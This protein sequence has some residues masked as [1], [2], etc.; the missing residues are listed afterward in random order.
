M[1]NGN[2]MRLPC[3]A[4][5]RPALPYN[6]AALLTSALAIYLPHRV[7]S[8][9]SEKIYLHFVCYF[10]YIFLLFSIFTKL[11]FIEFASNCHDL[12]QRQTNITYFGNFH[13]E[14][15]LLHCCPH[16]R[17]NTVFDILL[18]GVLLWS[19]VIRIKNCSFGNY[20]IAVMAMTF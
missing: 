6:T 12:L 14:I 5:P 8:E 7:Y 16:L 4:L 19:S 20:I 3:P 1:E 18:G 10:L 17:F 2:V 9:N 13:S 11:T 15:F